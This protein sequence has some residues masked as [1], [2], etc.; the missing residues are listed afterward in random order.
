MRDALAAM[1]AGA[2]PA[3][4]AEVIRQTGRRALSPPVLSLALSHPEL[5]REACEALRAEPGSRRTALAILARL[6]N[7]REEWAALR[8]VLREALADRP[9]DLDARREALRVELLS[10]LPD[11][12]A[13]EEAWRDAATLPPLAAL[14]YRLQR[15]LAEGGAADPAPLLAALEARMATLAGADA[16]PALRRLAAARRVALVGNGSGPRGRGLGAEIDAH[17]TVVRVNYPV[18]SGFGADVGTRTDVVVF[19]EEL[20]PELP[21]LLAREPAY[22]TL[23]ALGLRV[24]ARPPA[25]A[26]EP[27]RVPAG[28]AALVSDLAYERSTTGFFAILLTGLLLRREVT[29]HGFD[30]FAPGLPGHYFGPAS[31]ALRHELAY[32]R[33]FAATVLPA[34][35]PWIRRA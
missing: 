32:E 34:I 4:L 19:A 30:F 6:L 18:L 31:G 11:A 5:L 21:A 10:P 33:W 22:A 7:R 2:R 28:L 12:A 1:P 16:A 15:S 25:D 8:A 9:G 24:H 3:W 29:L 26:A 17:D 23:P 14:S 20:R 27:P 35:A 13:R